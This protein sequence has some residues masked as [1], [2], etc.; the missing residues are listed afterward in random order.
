MH[1]ELSFRDAYKQR[2]QGD[3]KVGPPNSGVGRQGASG[4]VESQPDSSTWLPVSCIIAK[5]ASSSDAP[6][7]CNKSYSKSSASSVV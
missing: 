5:A 1:I 7:Q 3:S 6:K 2:A 4:R